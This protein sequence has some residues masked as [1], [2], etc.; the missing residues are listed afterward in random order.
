MFLF[1]VFLKNIVLVCPTPRAFLQVWQR[2]QEAVLTPGKSRFSD[3]WLPDSFTRGPLLHRKGLSRGS[4]CS[5]RKTQSPRRDGVL[6][7][8]P[9]LELLGPALLSAQLPNA[10][11]TSFVPDAFPLEVAGPVQS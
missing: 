7:G 10:F 1:L 11:L 4:C 8:G 2:M 6:P 5:A 9:F 3:N